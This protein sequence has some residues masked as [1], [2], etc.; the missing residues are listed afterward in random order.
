M[1]WPYIALILPLLVLGFVVGVQRHQNKL[2]GDITFARHRRAHPLAKKHLKTALVLM[3]KSETVSFFEEL[4]RAVLG[5][6]GNRLN[7]SERGL[8][9]IQLDDSLSRAAVP[10]SM[11]TGL[12]DLLTICDL[13]RFSPGG[14]DSNKLESAYEDAAALIVA[15]GSSFDKKS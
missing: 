7:V 13:G 8:T 6:I 9:R 5:F 11:R 10:Q 14:I 1:K 12:T 3:K 4:E 2:A 15:I